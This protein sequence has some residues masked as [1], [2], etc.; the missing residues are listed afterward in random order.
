MTA[1]RAPLGISSDA[2]EPKVI[3]PLAPAGA[4]LELST[5]LELV[6]VLE[7]GAALLLLGSSSEP[8]AARRA[9]RDRAAPPAKV[10]FK[11]ERRLIRWAVSDG[12]TNEAR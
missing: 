9:G 11:I 2:L 5:A 8:H 6:A 3:V 7:L 4:A 12:G 10:P 1:W